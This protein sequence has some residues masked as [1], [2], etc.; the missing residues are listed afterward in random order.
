MKTPPSMLHLVLFAFLCVQAGADELPEKYAP[1]KKLL[2]EWD[3][4]V[5]LVVTSPSGAE[6][7]DYEKTASCAYDSHRDAIVMVDVEKD[8]WTKIEVTTTAEI[9]WDKETKIFKA[10]VYATDGSVRLFVIRETEGVLRYE[11]IDGLPGAKFH[12]EVSIDQK[13]RIIEAGQRSWPPPQK[14]AVEWEVT[15]SP[16]AN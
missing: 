8:P 10:M 3:G 4:M 5:R 1:Y 2:G 15:Y 16:K 9:R 11:H 12:C 6:K 7:V 13:D 14:T